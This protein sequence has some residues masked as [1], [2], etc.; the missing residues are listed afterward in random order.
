M[1]NTPVYT[2]AAS[3][4]ASVPAREFLSALAWIKADGANTAG[5]MSM[6]EVFAPNGWETPWHVHYTHD[7]YFYVLEGVISAQVGE[8]R[9]TLEAGNFAFGPRGIPHGYRVAGSGPAR[10]LMMTNDRDFAEFVREASRPASGDGFP[11]PSEPDI[12]FLMAAAR[13][14]GQD[15]LG[16]LPF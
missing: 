13:R 4:I 1:L 2:T 3:A 15:V 7:E 16:P 12:D 5:T 11:E 8:H 6:I 10:L 14:S 9:I